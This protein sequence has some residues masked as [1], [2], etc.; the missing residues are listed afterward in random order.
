MNRLYEKATSLESLVKLKDENVCPEHYDFRE[1]EVPTDYVRK[2]FSKDDVEK[3]T[4]LLLQCIINQTPKGS[5]YRFAPLWN[6][7][8]EQFL[9]ERDSAFIVQIRRFRGSSSVALKSVEEFLEILKNKR[10]AL[11]QK[12]DLPFEEHRRTV[13]QAPSYLPRY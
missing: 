1:C 10:N 7:Y 5:E 12:Y 8:R 6:L 11:C 9:A 3:N 4:K 2:L 13:V